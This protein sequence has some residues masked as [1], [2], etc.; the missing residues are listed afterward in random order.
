[1]LPSVVFDNLFTVFNNV[2]M[3]G[4]FIL[5]FL[6]VLLL[7]FGIINMFSTKFNDSVVRWSNSMRG[8]KTQI[9]KNTRIGYKINGFLAILGGT[10]L[11]IMAWY[12]NATIS[13]IETSPDN[14]KIQLITPAPLNY[15]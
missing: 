7:I 4:V 8:V 1:M 13:K 12:I 6:G 9:T 2:S 11:L 14:Q 10:F 5:L 3:E 15:K